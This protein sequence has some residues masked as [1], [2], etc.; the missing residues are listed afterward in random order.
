[1]KNTNRMKI[2]LNELKKEKK[3]TLNIKWVNRKGE[4]KSRIVRVAGIAY[5]GNGSLVVVL[6]DAKQPNML[7]NLPIG[8]ITAIEGVSKFRSK[9]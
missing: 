6:R 7:F 9:T 4:H 5:N 8:R 2:I 3:A 1:M